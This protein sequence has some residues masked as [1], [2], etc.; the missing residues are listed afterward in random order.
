MLIFLPLALVLF[1]LSQGLVIALNGKKV[2]VPDIPRTTLTLGEGKTLN[3]VVIGD[4]TA[5]GQ[6]ADYKDGIAYRSAAF[7]AEKYQVKL[8]NLGVSG[9]TA[10]TVL[11]GQVGA[12]VKLKADVV[13]VCVGANDVTHLSPLSNIKENMS[14]IIDRLQNANP[15]V[16]IFLTGAPAMG[17]VPRFPQPTK[18]LAGLRTSQVNK[19]MDRVAKEKRVTRLKI[20]EKTGPIFVKNPRLFAADK[21]HPTDEGYA[22]WV[23]VIIEALKTV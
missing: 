1:V 5:V 19:I 17:S 14:A 13:L 9:A 21:F 11:S 16:R 15:N 4:S 22:V 20:A 2:S 7:L 12:A 6:G 8:T 18:F 23:P 3:Y 10:G